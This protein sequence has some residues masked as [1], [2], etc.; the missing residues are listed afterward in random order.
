MRRGLR[1]GLPRWT[2]GSRSCRNQPPDRSALG[3]SGPCEA[4]VT[5]RTD[6]NQTRGRR[7]PLFAGALGVRIWVRRSLP[8]PWTKKGLQKGLR[9]GESR[10]PNP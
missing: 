8:I 9:D 3:G 10:K 2:T 6:I 1:R 5:E 4:P 7:L